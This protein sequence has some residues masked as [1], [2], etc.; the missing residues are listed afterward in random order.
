MARVKLSADE[1]RQITRI[2]DEMSPRVEEFFADAC[3]ALTGEEWELLDSYVKTRLRAALEVS[4]CLQAVADT[5]GCD[6]MSYPGRGKE[7]FVAASLRAWRDSYSPIRD[8]WRIAV[9]AERIEGGEKRV[10]ADVDAL[11]AIAADRMFR[12]FEQQCR[13]LLGSD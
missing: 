10:M 6:S 4:T 1:S 12:S 3:L 8:P 13:E 11:E 7:T 2:L 5:V 9:L